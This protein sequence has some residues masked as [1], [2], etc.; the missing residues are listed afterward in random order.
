MAIDSSG[1]SCSF[2]SLSLLPRRVLGGCCWGSN[3]RQIHKRKGIRRCPALSMWLPVRCSYASSRG[4]C[5]LRCPVLFVPRQLDAGQQHGHRLHAAAVDCEQD[6]CDSSEWMCVCVF[7]QASLCAWSAHIYFEDQLCA[8]AVQLEGI[9]PKCGAA[10][11][12]RQQTDPRARAARCSA[13]GMHSCL[14]A[15]H[16]GDRTKS[17][18]RTNTQTLQ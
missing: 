16:H 10:Y 6:V 17:K 8:S 14:T 1:R 9:Q 11:S 3:C 18:S 4:P 12:K 15:L 5:L 2:P 7:V 13:P